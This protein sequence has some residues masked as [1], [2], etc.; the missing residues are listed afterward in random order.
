MN[1]AADDLVP[2][3]TSE[4]AGFDVVLR[5][6]DRRQVDE[7]LDRVDVALND[8]DTRHAEDGERMTALQV[9]A[10]QVQEQLAEAERRADGRP[11]AASVLTGAMAQMLALAEAEAARLRSEAQVEVEA[12]HTQA[13]AEATRLVEQAKQQAARESS[14]QS[15]RLQTREREIAKATQL[16]ESSTLQAQ[17]DA[18]A[19]RS[20]A[21]R[22]AEAELSAGKREASALR[23]AAQ[24]DAETTTDQ[25][26]EDVQQ[27][28]ERARGEAA[29]M[30]AAARREVEDKARQ[31]DAISAQ[32]QALR[33]AVAAAAAPLGLD[34]RTSYRD[35]DA[36]QQLATAPRQDPSAP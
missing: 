10:E 4:A 2:L 26:R 13:G 33:D 18:E 27:L 16:V 36:T 22:E 31:R 19:V 1:D 14:E 20:Q 12:L 28:H 5:G 29:A 8:A 24:R 30:T 17:R 6:Y 15:A 35:P 3:P 7:Y 21:H 25:A 9:E 11:E 23:A 32:M 34:D